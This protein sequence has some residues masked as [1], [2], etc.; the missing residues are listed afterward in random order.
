MRYDISLTE[1][2]ASQLEVSHFSNYVLVALWLVYRLRFRCKQAERFATENRF[3]ADGFALTKNTQTGTA[4]QL[5][6]K[7]GFISLDSSM[8]STAHTTVRH[9]ENTCILPKQ[10]T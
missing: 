3:F 6:R 5:P 10:G 7:N 9:V 8:C 4:T 2:F 1:V